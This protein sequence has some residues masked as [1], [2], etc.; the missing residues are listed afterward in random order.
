MI[1]G[2]CPSDIRALREWYIPPRAEC[3]SR[4]YYNFWSLTILAFKKTRKIDYIFKCA[5][6]NVCNVAVI[7]FAVGEMGP[8]AFRACALNAQFI[9]CRWWGSNHPRTIFAKRQKKRLVFQRVFGCG[10]GIWTSWPSGYEPDELPDCSTPRYMV[11]EAGVE[12]VREK[13]SRDFKSRASA[14]SAIPA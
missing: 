11:P 3:Y 1:F 7:Y 4:N 6:S 8:D 12:P 9:E 2:P 14:Y 10:D 5:S 13:I